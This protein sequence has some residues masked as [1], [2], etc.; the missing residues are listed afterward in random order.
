MDE[1]LE[2]AVSAI[3]RSRKFSAR[4]ALVDLKESTGKVLRDCFKQFGIK[5]WLLPTMLWS[6][7]LGKN[8]KP[9]Y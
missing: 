3:P 2:T 5:R 4:V 7:C 8:S 6:V 9:A 1:S